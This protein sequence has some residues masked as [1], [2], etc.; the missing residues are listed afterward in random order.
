MDSTRFDALTRTLSETT[1]RRSLIR[2]LGSLALGGLLRPNAIDAMK[3]GNRKKVDNDKKGGK[4]KANKVKT[5]GKKG[6]VGKERASATSSLKFNPPKQS[7]LALGDSL[8]FGFQFDIFNSALS[9]CAAG[10]PPFLTILRVGGIAGREVAPRLA[11]R[12]TAER[13]G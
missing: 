3:R 1:T 10:V 8:A 4:A 7:Y 13:Y 2:L 6:N 12:Y 9:S 11:I 5:N